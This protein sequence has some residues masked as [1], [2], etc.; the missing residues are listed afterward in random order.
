MP[1]FVRMHESEREKQKKSHRAL[2]MYMCVCVC[3][4]VQQMSVSLYDR[5]TWALAVRVYVSA[6]GRASLNCVCVY[7]CVASFSLYVPLC[8]CV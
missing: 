5:T 2:C 8:V 1:V 6:L 4:C 3:V 7:P